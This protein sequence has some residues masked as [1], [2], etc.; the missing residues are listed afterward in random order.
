[1]SHNF[2]VKIQFVKI[3]QGYRSF[4]ENIS[5]T[6]VTQTVA[7]IPKNL[8]RDNLNESSFLPRLLGSHFNFHTET[9]EKK[10]CAEIKNVL[11][12]WW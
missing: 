8:L 6:I 3:M 7:F 11:R 5:L 10:L 9:K 12:V 4:S 2:L 1:M